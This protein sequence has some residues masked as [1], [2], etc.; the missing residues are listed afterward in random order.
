MNWEEYWHLM[1]N[2]AHWAFEI[3]VEFITAIPVYYFAK[4]RQRLHDKKY[5]GIDHK[6]DKTTL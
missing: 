5:H 2:S 4:W 1:G 6:N 3:S